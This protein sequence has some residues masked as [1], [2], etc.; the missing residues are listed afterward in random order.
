LGQ[1]FLWSDLLAYTLGIL[2]IFAIHL[3]VIRRN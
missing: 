2:L 3:K 1:G